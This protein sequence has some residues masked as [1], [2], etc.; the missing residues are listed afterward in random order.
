M[1]GNGTRE[2]SIDKL[3]QT[4]YDE[5]DDSSANNAFV[6]PGEGDEVIQSAAPSNVIQS[7]STFKNLTLDDDLQFDATPTS[8]NEEAGA[9]QGMMEFDEDENSLRGGS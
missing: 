7:K 3:K 8:V 1:S 5:M 6:Q 9:L 2:A 4:I